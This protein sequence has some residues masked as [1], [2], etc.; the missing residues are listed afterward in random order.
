MLKFY[1]FFSP[2]L[3]RWS[4]SFCILLCC[5]TLIDLC[6]FDHPWWLWN[7]PNLIVVYDPFY[8]FLDS[9][10]YYFVENFCIY[11]NQRCLLVIFFFGIV[12]VRFCYQGDGDFIEWFWEWSLLFNLLEEFEK[13]HCKLFCLVE[14]PSDIIQSWNCFAET[15]FLIT[16][17][18]SFLVICLFK[19]SVFSSFSFS[20]LYVPKTYPFLLGFHF[21]DM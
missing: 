12:F 9:V 2:C 15:F 14:F 6:M 16:D 7:N 21:V 10:C 18:I 20:R 11:V 1:Q 17:S 3:L 19:L 13:N 4:H 5:I 8:V